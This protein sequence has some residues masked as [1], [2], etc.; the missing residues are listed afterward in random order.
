MFGRTWRT[1]DRRAGP[2]GGPG[3][4]HVVGGITCSAA[5]P[6][7]PGEDGMVAMPIATIA[8]SV[9]GPKIGTEHDREQQRGEREQQ[10]VAA[11]DDLAEPRARP[12]PPG[13]PAACRR[14]RRCRP[15]RSPTS[16]VV[17]APTMS[18]L[19]IVPAELVGAEQV[20]GPGA[21]RA[22]R[23]GRRTWRRS[24]VQKKETSA[25]STTS[26]TSAPR[27]SRALPV[28]PL[29]AL[30]PQPRI[31]H[32]VQDVDDEV[33]D[34][35]GQSPARITMACTEQQV[36]VGDPVEQEAAEPRDHEHAL[37]DDGADQQ[38]R[39]LQAEHG[40][41]GDGGVAQPVAH[42]RAAR[43]SGPWRARCAGSPLRST[44]ST[45]ERT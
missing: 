16:S 38:R 36:A 20:R 24:G 33:D 17:R 42:E 25:A 3:G 18:R 29:H 43:A 6:G 4:Q 12:S 41:D 23:S 5:G 13:C 30:A 8:V 7:Q 39:E 22:E 28:Q 34:Q 26:T 32:G 10:V 2:A 31:E 44:S 19:T 11:H 27:R 45:A 14:P 40:D 1:R 15:R 21:E 37:D 35:H 9:L